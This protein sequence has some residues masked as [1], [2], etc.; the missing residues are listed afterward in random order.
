MLEVMP[1][2]VVAVGQ[3]GK[4]VMVNSQAERLFSRPRREMVGEPV[5]M[6]VPDELAAA[7]ERHRERYRAWPDVRPMG[8]A[9]ELLAKRGDGTT[10]PVEISLSTLS[11]G[12]AGLVL[13]AARD[14]SR[15]HRAWAELVEAHAAVSGQLAELENRHQGLLRVNKLSELLRAVESEDEIHQ[16]VAGNGPRLFPRLAGRLFLSDVPRTE[17]VLAA[18]W[19]D[20]ATLGP[21]STPGECWA[22]R[23]GRPCGQRYPDDAPRCPHVSGPGDYLCIPL[24]SFDQTLGVLHLGAA[25]DGGGQPIEG[26]DEALATTMTGSVASCLSSLR[27]RQVLESQA[28]RDSLTGL[29]NRR[30]MEQVVSR[31]LKRA[32]RYGRPVG[33]ALLDIDDFKGFNDTYGHDAADS[34]LRDLARLLERTVRTEDVVCR[35]GGDEV[36]LVLPDTPPEG[37]AAKADALRAAVARMKPRHLGGTLPSVTVQVGT[38]AY[39][40]DGDDFVS[41]F[42]AADSALLRAKGERR[43]SLGQGSATPTTSP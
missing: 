9:R 16:A 3:D 10:L 41:L 33:F 15:A 17:V 11:A 28:T 25:G 31:E 23:L 35:Y 37:C 27:L 20:S 5:E 22:M 4:I 39:P 2:A 38:S 36:A 24:V 13:A 21:L 8:V 12:P 34:L 42:R 18:S 30:H 6:L 40:D 32:A 29:F 26:A 1:D 43:A 14:V 19:G 7:H